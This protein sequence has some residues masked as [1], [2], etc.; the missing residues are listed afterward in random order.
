MTL[1]FKVC[2]RTTLTRALALGA[3][4]QRPFL[5]FIYLTLDSGE[6]GYQQSVLAEQL[7]QLLPRGLGMSQQEAVELLEA[8]GRRATDTVSGKG[9]PARGGGM[10]PGQEGEGSGER[11]VR[12]RLGQGTGNGKVCR[13]MNRWGAGGQ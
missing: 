4:W 3:F 12:V 5:R 10:G 8:G 2:S 6:A 9:G 1:C 7:L 11:N 13:G